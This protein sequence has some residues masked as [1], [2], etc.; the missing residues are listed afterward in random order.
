MKIEIIEHCFGQ[1][2]RIDDESLFKHEYDT[3][4]DEEIASLQ[5]KLLKEL[6]DIKDNLDMADWSAIANMLVHRSN[7]FEYDGEKSSSS[8]CEQCSNINFTE[9]YNKKN[10][11]E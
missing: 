9:T 10:S 6:S 3:R 2:V 5:N 4:S 11:C 8:N 7:K 1:D